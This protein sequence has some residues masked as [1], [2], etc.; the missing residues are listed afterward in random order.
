MNQESVGPALKLNKNETAVAE[1]VTRTIIKPSKGWVSLG[2]GE[3]WEY[4]EL[5]YYLTWRDIKV[6][7]KQTVLGFSWAILQPFF[8]MV[9]FGVIFGRVA[10]ISTNRIPGPIFYYTGLIAY[11]FFTNALAQS[12][13]SLLS[14]A[15]VIKKIYFPRLA[16]PTASVLALLVDFA[17][18]FVVLLGMML[19]YRIYPSINILW[20]P[21][22]LLLVTVNTLGMGIWFAALNAQFRDVRYIIP[23]LNSSLMFLTP[24][25]FPVSELPQNLQLLAALNPLTGVVEGMRWALLGTEPASFSLIAVSSV[26]GIVLLI[27]GALYFRRL[28]KTIVDVL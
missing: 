23:F 12:A 7:Y 26:V 6:R 22:F 18:M 1:D 5:L 28:E 27:T 9:V 13:N 8:T 24:I 2:L 20:T 3:L 15:A 4:R 16:V 14:S 17:L 19:Y 11:Y 21:F 25:G 10:G